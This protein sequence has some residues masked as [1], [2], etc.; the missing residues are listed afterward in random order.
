MNA[1]GETRLYRGS[2]GKNAL[3]AAFSL[4]WSLF[5][6]L[7]V[8]LGRIYSH[9]GIFV[10]QAGSLIFLGFALFFVA[11]IIRSLPTLRLTEKGFELSTGLGSKQYLWS[12]CYDCHVAQPFIRFRRRGY[13]EG[14]ILNQ[15]L[16]TTSDICEALVAWQARRKHDAA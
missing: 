1:S 15:F 12:E 14:A 5:L 11:Q 3:V 4:G 6:F 8:R 13:G 9:E 16:G 10:C 2:P 7:L